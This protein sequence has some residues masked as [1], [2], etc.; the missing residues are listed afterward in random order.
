MFW[1]SNQNWYF[2]GV[3]YKCE[4][5]VIHATIYDI[6]GGH[7]ILVMINCGLRK[8]KILKRNEDWKKAKGLEKK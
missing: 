8:A 5:I 3:V 1:V 7:N 6:W 2:K 4:R